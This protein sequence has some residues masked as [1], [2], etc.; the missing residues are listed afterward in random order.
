VYQELLQ[1]PQLLWYVSAAFSNRLVP[2]RAAADAF[3]QVSEAGDTSKDHEEED[4]HEMELEDEVC[5]PLPYC[6]QSVCP[7]VF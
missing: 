3:Y 2:S 6:P 5:D 7:V 1:R 4:S